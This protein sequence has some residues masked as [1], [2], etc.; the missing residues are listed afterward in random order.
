LTYA[1]DNKTPFGAATTKDID[2]NNPLL[3]CPTKTLVHSLSDNEW[4][5]VATRRLQNAKWKENAWSSLVKD[6]SIKKQMDRLREL[7]LAHRGQK[8]QNEGSSSENE[9][10]DDDSENEDQDDDSDNNQ[11]IDNFRGKGKG[12]TFLLY[13][14]PG[15]GKTMLAECLS[16]EQARPLYRVNLGMLTNLDKWEAKIEEIFRQAHSWDA[17]LLIDEAEVVLAERTQENMKQSAWVAGT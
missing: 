9:D 4:Y 5:Y 13:G 7:A 11:R 17:I 3:L 15:V 14:P 12:L 8:S 16:E 10:Q 6:P 2:E 1:R